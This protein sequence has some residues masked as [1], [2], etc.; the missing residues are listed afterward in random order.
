MR[1]LEGINVLMDKLWELVMYREAWC[2]W[3]HKQ[4]DTTE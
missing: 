1:W 3:V 4:L 2:P